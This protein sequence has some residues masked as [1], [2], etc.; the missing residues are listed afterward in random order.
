MSDSLKATPAC[1]VHV[2]DELVLVFYT[3]YDWPNGGSVDVLLVWWAG[4]YG[5]SALG[6]DAILGNGCGIKD[7]NYVELLLGSGMT[8]GYHYKNY[9]L[10]VSSFRLFLIDIF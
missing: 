8:A 6:V 1:P 5:F 9:I 2:V 4:E 3:P 7:Q 10:C